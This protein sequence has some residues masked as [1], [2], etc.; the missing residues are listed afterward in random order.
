MVNHPGAAVKVQ[1]IEKDDQYVL[2]HC[3]KYLAR[4]NEDPRHDFG[5]YEPDD[6]RAAVCE[7]WRFP[8]VDTHWD[9]A[10]AE[11]SFPFNDVTFVYDGRRTAP[12]EVEVVGTFAPLHSPVPLRPLMFAG[13]PTGLFATTVRVPKGQ[14]HLYKFAVD[15]TYGLDSVNPQ[16]AV[17][18]NGETWSRFFTDACTVP[19]A[20]DRAER[21]VLG[22]LVGH[23]LPFRLDENRRFIRGVYESL[24]RAGR[25]EEFPLSYQLDEEVGTV[26]YI[27]KIISREEQHNADDYHTCLRIIGDLVR[28]RCGGLDP[29]VAPPEVYADLY[30]QMETEK[31]PGWD[32]G[33]YGSPRYFL[34][35]LRRHAMTGAFVHPRHHGNSG[36]AGWMYLESRFRDSAGATLFDWRRALEAPLGHNTEYRG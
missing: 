7:A 22:R 4:D 27:D 17:V 5:Q 26:N 12:R 8:L 23:L 30:A 13:E 35:L 33:R 6:A 9:G 32:Y 34:L 14:V 20:L 29:G 31:A 10:S 25:S 2:N 16:R 15:G 1:I 28:A 24:D 21:E 36:A 19:L 3:T 18:D 11:T